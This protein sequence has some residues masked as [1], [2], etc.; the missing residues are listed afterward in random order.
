MT[1][2]QRRKLTKIRKELLRLPLELEDAYRKRAT[3]NKRK[4][5]DNFESFTVYAVSFAGGLAVSLATE[6]GIMLDRDK[7]RRR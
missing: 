7:K 5:L 2:Y 4:K 6:L 1:D 3:K